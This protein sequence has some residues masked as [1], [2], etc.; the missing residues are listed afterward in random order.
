M[1]QRTREETEVQFQP[2]MALIQPPRGPGLSPTTAEQ[3]ALLRDHTPSG[4]GWL[5]SRP[6][7][8][9][10]LVWEAAMTR[11]ALQSLILKKMDELDRWYEH[12]D[13]DKIIAGERA[14]VY[15]VADMMARAGFHRLHTIGLALH[16][17]ETSEPVKNFL[18]RCLKA[19]QSRRRAGSK[20]PAQES[21]MLTPPDV[22]RRYGVSPDTVRGWI[23]SGGLH[24][25]NVSKC[26]RPRYRIPLEALKDFDKRHLP[27]IVP[28]L[29]AQRRRR[30][31][32][33]GLIVTRFS[34]GR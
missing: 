18:S 19:L 28:A 9:G 13:E 16:V 14:I 22:A 12:L 29:P 30:P 31:K 2:S 17:D 5:Q 3:P 6:L 7:P 25:V 20:G 11:K 32:P 27:R 23:A 34:S 1:T 21:E 8:Q 4:A 15:E 10:M 24:A 26:R 33:A